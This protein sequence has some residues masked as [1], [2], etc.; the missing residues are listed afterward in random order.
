MRHDTQP[1]AVRWHFEQDRQTGT[2]SWRH[3][4]RNGTIE[5][6]ST[7]YSGFAEAYLDAMRFG[8]NPAVDAYTAGDGVHVAYHPSQRRRD[9][10]RAQEHW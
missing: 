10:H 1:A 8:F 3:E 7:P 2:W 5:H 4:L 6:M 9:P